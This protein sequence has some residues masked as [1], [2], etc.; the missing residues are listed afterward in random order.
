MS[1][2]NGNFNCSNNNLTSLEGAPKEVGGS[3]YCY[4]NNLTTLEG[5]PKT[6]GGNFDC[7]NNPGPNGKGFTEDDVRAVCDVKGKIYV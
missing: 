2:V 7:G 3:C 5:A 1:K 4:E 6:V